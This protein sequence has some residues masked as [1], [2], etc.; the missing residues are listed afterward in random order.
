MI[1]HVTNPI[2]EHLIH[3]LRNPQTDRKEFRATL[4]KVGEHLGVDIARDLVTIEK[5]VTTVMGES[6]T[7]QVVAEDPL[8]VP[9]LRAGIPLGYGL[10][11]VFPYAD[12]GF[13]GAMR[14]EES[15]NSEATISYTTTPEEVQG[16]VL[17]LADTMI[18]TGGSILETIKAIKKLN[19]ARIVLAG[20][21]AAKQGLD[22]ILR[23]CPQVDIY[24][25]AIDPI[26]NEK[27]Y[28]VPGLGDAG[29]RCYGGKREKSLA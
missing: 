13:I 3:Q 1:K 11:K 12:M 17:I 27:N 2:L 15:P 23:Y 22:N 28:I 21:I 26:L 8:L 16:K 4:E 20:A 24:V 25:A 19:P 9:I 18:A 6:A 10:H 7:H 5:S 29:D 14:N